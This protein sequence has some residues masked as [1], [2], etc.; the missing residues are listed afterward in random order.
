MRFLKVFGVLV[1]LAGP[2]VLA[3]LAAPS[4]FHAF[5]SPAF[6]QTMQQFDRA[7]RDFMLLEGRGS[8]VGV[9]IADVPET[10]VRVDEVEPNSAAEKA[11]VKAGDVITM[12]DGERVRSGRQF[13]R[14]VQE[15]PPGRTVK[16]TV[17]RDGQQKDL[18]ITPDS[19]RRANFR[20]DG[21]R[22][23]EQWGDRVPPFNFNFDFDWQDSGS[24]RRLGVSVQ[25]LTDQ[26]ASYFG[27]R[28]GVLVTAVTE[29][30]PASRAGLKAG[31][32][33][34]SV[35]SESVESRDDLVRVLRNAAGRRQAEAPEIT[36]GITR[37]KK[38]STLKATLEPA[39]RAMR[40]RPV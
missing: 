40:G 4:A 22:L 8:E 1:T 37:D 17:T 20:I 16:M 9:R 7:A 21:D 23:R 34:T 2:I 35:N 12:F 26:L 30:S 31:D 29:G 36:I 3:V 10:G 32:V 19:G 15:T 28:R 38:E 33:I 14:L 13:S 27:V 18:Q 39:R 6:A 11:G 25:E 5:D 24:S